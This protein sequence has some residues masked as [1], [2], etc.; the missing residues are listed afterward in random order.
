MTGPAVNAKTLPL[1]FA[2]TCQ[3]EVFLVIGTNSFTTCVNRLKVI[4]ESRAV[5]LVVHVSRKSDITKLQQRFNGNGDRVQ[6]LSGSF[7]LDQ[8]TTLGRPLTQGVVDR[9]FVDLPI[10]ED[11]LTRQIYMQCMKLRIPVNSFQKP[12]YSNF[13]FISTYNDPQRSGLQIAVATNGGGC[14]LA[15]RIRREIVTSLPANISD[16]VANMTRLRDR[17]LKEDRRKLLKDDRFTVVAQSAID[18]LWYGLDE[19]GWESHKLNKLVSEVCISR[20]QRSFRRTR[21]LAQFMEYYPLHE[22]AHLDLGMLDTVSLDKDNGGTGS[23]T[24]FTYLSERRSNS[25]VKKKKLDAFDLRADTCNDGGSISLVGSGPGAVSMLTMGAFHVIRTADLILADKL[26]PTS[27]LDLIRPETDIFI[28]RK[29]PGNA[30]RAQRELLKKGLDALYKGKKVV[31][32]KQGDPYVFGR[33]GEEYLFFSEKGFQPTV[34]PGL[35]SALTSTLVSCIPVTQRGVADQVLICS[36][37]GK[38][39]DLP[40]VPEFVSSRTTV[41]LMALHRVEVLTKI[42]IEKGWPIDTAAAVIERASCKDQ[43]IARTTLAF[44]PEMVEEI[45]SRP[46][47]LLVLGNAVTA[48]VPQLQSN[49]NKTNKYHVEE[50]FSDICT[51]RYPGFACDLSASTIQELAQIQALSRMSRNAR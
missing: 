5:P 39:G 3:D 32:L 11:S 16:V 26:V 30:E 45:G 4:Q 38:N 42:L 22:L 27:I 24:P 51:E 47:G 7:C 44:V 35:T 34:V 36:G 21:W 43:R 29:F 15:N 20:R 46:P 50:G 9:V 19:D 40:N 17:I 10:S 1:I 41:F 2:S 6:V 8:L 37:T 14:I 12:E 25:A 23:I 31:R 49:F 28:A 48:L 33:G 13:H 18:N